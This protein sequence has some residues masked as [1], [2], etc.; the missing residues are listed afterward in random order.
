MTASSLDGRQGARPA[1]PARPSIRERRAAHARSFDTNYRFSKA[2]VVE[3]RRQVRA[4]GQRA[5]LY[6]GGRNARMGRILARDDPC[7]WQLEK[8]LNQAARRA[9]ARQREVSR[10]G[11]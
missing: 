9:N 7:A 10:D 11:R 4:D 6:R 1:T 3:E 2:A 8:R 5:Y